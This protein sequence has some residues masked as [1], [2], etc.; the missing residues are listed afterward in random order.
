VLPAYLDFR[1][2]YV[3]SADATARRD[4]V[5]TFVA[6]HVGIG[7]SVIAAVCLGRFGGNLSVEH[8]TVYVT[9]LV[10][11]IL[12]PTLAVC[13]WLGHLQRK[14]AKVRS[15][16]GALPNPTATIVDGYEYRSKRRLLGLPLVHICVGGRRLKVAKGWIAHGGFACG[17]LFAS[18]GFAIAPI[19]FG[20]FAMGLLAFGG[21]VAGGL[22]IGGMA[23]AI[24]AIGGLAIGWF[25]H[26][27]TVMVLN[28]DTAAVAASRD[29][30][31]L[32][33]GMSALWSSISAWS[34]VWIVPVLLIGW[35][36]VR[37]RNGR[38]R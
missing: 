31:V 38:S 7:V 29:H 10:L 22:A 33:Y 20:G 37:R 30:G 28:P 8:P 21:M 5:R 34:W 12:L 16:V 17:G 14:R 36:L 9:A 3:A 27:G 23:A 18:G 11:G 13:L 32:H 6:I 4:V 24:F 25:A 19:A 1:A 2:Q 35:E 26:G 15:M